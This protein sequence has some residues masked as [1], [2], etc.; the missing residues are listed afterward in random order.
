M[1]G[2]VCTLSNAYVNIGCMDVV[3]LAFGEVREWHQR[4]VIIII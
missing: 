4:D 1:Y 2:S 3:I